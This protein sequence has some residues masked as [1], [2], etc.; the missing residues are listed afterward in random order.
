MGLL[1]NIAG[2]NTKFREN[3]PAYTYE[4]KVTVIENESKSF[5]AD[6]FC[7]LVEYL[8]VNKVEPDQVELYEIFKNEETKLHK[9]LC[10]SKEG[11]WLSRDE[12]CVA[13]TERYP[14]Y[15][16]ESGCR[17]EDRE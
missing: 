10:V 13:F 15:I 1:C 8:V 16:H 4:A 17:S 9:E 7:A 5:F 11:R 3:I 2:P 12:L 6:T 14:G